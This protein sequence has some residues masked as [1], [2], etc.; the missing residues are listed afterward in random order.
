MSLGKRGVQAGAGDNVDPGGNSKGNATRQGEGVVWAWLLPN[1]ANGQQKQTQ[2]DLLPSNPVL[3][4]SI[5]SPLSQSPSIRVLSLEYKRSR[6]KHHLHGQ[7]LVLVQASE[8]SR[9][10]NLRRRSLSWSVVHVQYRVTA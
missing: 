9:A 3:L 10:Q 1:V 6:R 5:Q 7:T 8:A 2:N 4:P